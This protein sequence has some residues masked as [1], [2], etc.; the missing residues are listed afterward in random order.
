MKDSIIDFSRLDNIIRSI[1][2][3]D[4]NNISELFSYLEI[5][6]SDWSV[7]TAKKEFD[8][9]I[10]KRVQFKLKRKNPDFTVFCGIPCAG[11]TTKSDKFFESNKEDILVRFDDIME[12][13]S[14]YK[15]LH[16]KEDNKIAF[17]KCELIA[18]VIGYQL[19]K[20]SI[21][22]GLQIIFEHGSTP[23]QHVDL[24]ML[25][26]DLYK[27]NFKM[28]YIDVP[29]QTALDRNEKGRNNNRYTDPVMIKER[30]FLMKSLIGEYK[31]KFLVEIVSGLE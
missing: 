15:K 17:K 31:T 16:A 22:K 6:P 28:I 13:L 12:S 7:E 26:K 23:K 20:I 21:E 1:T 27:Y 18:R 5:E 19:L 25:I 29:L 30:H 11:K 24:Y 4:Y 3:F 9:I 14:Y 8:E 2:K 10:E